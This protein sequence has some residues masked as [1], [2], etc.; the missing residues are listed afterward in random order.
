[1]PCSRCAT[2]EAKQVHFQAGDLQ[3]WSVTGQLTDVLHCL[4]YS[5]VDLRLDSEL[6]GS[7]RHVGKGHIR[8][9][10]LSAYAWC[11][12]GDANQALRRIDWSVCI[13]PIESVEPSNIRR[14]P[15]IAT[16]R[17]TLEIAAVLQHGLL[18][19]SA[20]AQLTRLALRTKLYV[21]RIV[22]GAVEE[23]AQAQGDAGVLQFFLLFFLFQRAVRGCSWGGTQRCCGGWSRGTGRRWGRDAV[24]RRLARS[25]H[26]IGCHRG[27]LGG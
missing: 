5:K 1:M 10:G 2:A 23:Q 9:I 27:V 24:S 18:M 19:L 6:T 11:V 22:S 8:H 16:A 25:R 14:L 15:P 26:G 7:Q 13:V 3:C 21:L 20:V 12:H 17:V 4:A